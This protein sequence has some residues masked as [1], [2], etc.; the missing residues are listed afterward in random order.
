MDGNGRWARTKG[1]RR[2]F[3]HREALRA[4]R[5]V[6]E[7]GV[8][9]NLGYITLYTFSTENWNRPKTEVLALMELL[10]STIRK[11]TPLLLD[12]NIR[13]R[14]I[15]HLEDLPGRPHREL[16][17][18]ME[19]TKNN[20]GLTL[21][22]ALSYGGRSDILSAVNKIAKKAQT[23]ELEPGEVT[24]KVLRSQ[25]STHYL[26]DPELMI[27]T[28]GEFRVSNFLLWELAYTEIYITEKYW[29]D[30]SREDLYAAIVDYQNRERRFGK[31]SEQLT[32]R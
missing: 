24:E 15:G 29:P 8:E 2:I 7:A 31:I 21:T 9:L 14:A 26:P 20:T 16:M 1:N 22:L 25:M 6:I 3:G 28:S 32:A 11:E 10:V 19:L 27:R 30:F 17:K 13:L 5:E 4:V 23:G 18:S 12:K